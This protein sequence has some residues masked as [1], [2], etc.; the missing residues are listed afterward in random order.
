MW[1]LI[2]INHSRE[3]S[4]AFFRFKN[5]NFSSIAPYCEFKMVPVLLLSCTLTGCLLNNTY[6]Q[7][8]VPIANQWTVADR[9]ITR[10]DEKNTPYLAWWK[11][12]N[13][14]TLNHLIEKGL[15][16]NNSLNMSRGHILAAEGELK[17]IHN[18]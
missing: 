4:T 13:D 14:P 16:Y 9:N 18:Q 15:L 3:D 11:G 6:H 5:W 10:H 2:N 17:K 12:F 1:C 8:D 7:P